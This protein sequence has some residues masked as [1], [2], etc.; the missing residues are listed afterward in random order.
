MC[1]ADMVKR[2]LYLIHREIKFNKWPVELV[3]TVHDQIDTICHKDYAEAWATKMK[4]IMEDVASDILHNDLLKTDPT[5]S[6]VWQ[7]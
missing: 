3:M 1:A 4:Q 6:E 5:I 7:K 2:A